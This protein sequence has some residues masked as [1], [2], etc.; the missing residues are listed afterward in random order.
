MGPF[1][2]LSAIFYYAVGYRA[3]FSV[4]GLIGASARGSG[5]T[6]VWRTLRRVTADLPLSASSTVITQ[7]RPFRVRSE[8]TRSGAVES[9]CE[10][11][12]QCTGAGGTL[13]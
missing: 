5:C 4:P 10:Q 6:M 13:G 12:L 2:P 11:Q 8:D 1:H 9:E 7:A 3:A